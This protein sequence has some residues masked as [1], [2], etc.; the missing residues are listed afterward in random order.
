MPFAAL[1]LSAALAAMAMGLL[2]WCRAP[3]KPLW[4]LAIAAGEWGHYLSVLCLA[5]F[6][7][8]LSRRGAAKSSVW[9][10]AAILLLTPTL[11]AWRL[12]RWLPEACA[13]AFGR[14]ALMERPGAPGQPYP[15]SFRRLFRGI[16]G[17]SVVKT[18]STYPG[19]DGTMLKMDLYR[20][21]D[22]L[23]NEPIVVLIHGGSWRSGDHSELPA[24]NRYLAARGYAVAAI[25]YRLAPK[26]PFPAARDDVRAA[27]RFLI[28]HARLLGLDPSRIA[29]IG[30]SAGGQIA[31]SA[32]YDAPVA[33]IKGV[34]AFYSPN[35]LV[36][37]YQLPSN[38]LVLNS[39][40]VLE[41]YL[42]GPLA[43]RPTLYEEASPLRLV[44]SKTVPT[45]LVHGEIDPLVWSLHSHRLDQKLTQ[46]G[47]P[48][49][50]LDLPWA[51]HGCDA[52]LSGPSGQL[53][54][55]ALERFLAS[56]L[57]VTPDE[58]W[59]QRIAGFDGRS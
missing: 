3:A 9:L 30:R 59:A 24:L 12:S 17:V 58:Q 1:E 35:D 22:T 50:F 47:V 33:A 42:G 23:Q 18:T 4:Y 28:G 7:F 21:A 5:A 32:A 15:F 54:L 46:A 52:N 29:L 11:R 16:P 10:L 53:V 44:T 55:Y 36:L 31:L 51:T 14:H 57:K 20:R 37:A 34:A 25:E 13:S 26:H 49:L 40:E 19:A 38:P 41:S 8:S 6:V 27:V 48:H 56:V 2:T 45:L 39:R 43:T